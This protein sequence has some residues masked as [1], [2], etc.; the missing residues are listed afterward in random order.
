M[1]NIG[2]IQFGSGVFVPRPEPP[3][4]VLTLIV[5]VRGWDALDLVPDL[6]NHLA[7]RLAWA[8]VDRNVVPI[9][10]APIESIPADALAA[11]VGAVTVALDFNQP[12]PIYTAESD[13]PDEVEVR[14]LLSQMVSSRSADRAMLVS[15]RRSMMELLGPLNG[16]IG[17]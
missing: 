7:A 17:A 4:A 16:C 6:A 13:L 14:V 8:E 10:A 2:R 15:R 3:R 9:D 12:A 1:T 11:R 5:T